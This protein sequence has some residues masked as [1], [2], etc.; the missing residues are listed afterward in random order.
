MLVGES[1]LGDNYTRLPM[2]N[3]QDVH[4]MF[5]R[6]LEKRERTL[7]LEEQ[8]KKKPQTS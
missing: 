7:V 8:Q 5:N 2:I 3:V 4:K 1:R 6:I